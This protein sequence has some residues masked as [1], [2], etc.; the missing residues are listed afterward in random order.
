MTMKKY[1][2]TAVLLLGSAGACGQTALEACRDEIFDQVDANSDGVLTADEAA[3][4][5]LGLDSRFFAS[6]DRNGD[7]IL[8]YGEYKKLGFFV[9][10]EACPGVTECSGSD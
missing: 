5:P 3:S 2:V 7:G 9:S 10:C 4:K 8:D 1:F 6:A